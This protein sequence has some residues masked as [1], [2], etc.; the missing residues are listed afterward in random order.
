MTVTNSALVAAQSVLQK[1]GRNMQQL[2]PINQNLISVTRYSGTTTITVRSC[3][4]TCASRDYT[5]AAA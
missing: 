2:I 4:L 3:F 1:P 5:I